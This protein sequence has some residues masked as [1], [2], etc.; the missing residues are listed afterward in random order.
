MFLGVTKG[1][2]EEACNE[3]PVEACGFAY[4]E[5]RKQV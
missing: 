1:Q 3:S 5:A 4:R 2:E